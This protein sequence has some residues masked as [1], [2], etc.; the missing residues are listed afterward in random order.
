MPYVARKRGSKW[1]I[2]NK[3][4]GK[5]AGTSTTKRKAQASARIRNAAHK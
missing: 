3:N 1:A 2:V 4:T 5:S